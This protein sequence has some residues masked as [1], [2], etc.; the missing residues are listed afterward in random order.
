[1]NRSD[2]INLILAIATNLSSEDW[3]HVDLTLRQFELPWLDA[4]QGT[5]HDYVVEMV[6]KAD[7]QTLLELAEHLG[8]EDVDASGHSEDDRSELES[9][10]KL[11]ELQQALMISVATGGP[12]I[13]TVNDEYRER[14]LLIETALEKL[15]IPD[16]N[17][18]G[19]L[20]QW[21]G[22]WSDGT[23]PT[24]Q[25]RREYVTA[26][27]APVFESLSRRER[28]WSMEIVEPTGW[29]RVDRCITT[30]DQTLQAAS[31][32]E[33]FQSVGHL[34]REAIISLAQ[35]VYEP[36]VHSSLDDTPPS[37][38]DAKRMLTAYIAVELKGSA[39]EDCRRYVRS[40]Y[41]LAA[42][43]THSRNATRRDAMLC[44]EATRSITNAIAIISGRR[45]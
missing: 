41:Q 11:L 42:A 19:D 34:C 36:E 22:R 37:N 3:S 45:D 21:Y 4:W 6:E 7:D 43:L 24:Y 40:A 9:L 38:T 20:W 10:R 12:R 28:G 13:N 17:P 29:E 44:A 14:K 33:Q 39:N 1:M 23:L 32:E 31:N 5:Q 18:F 2:R 26:L 25:D 15:G 30:I 27:Y 35:A 16:L 8:L